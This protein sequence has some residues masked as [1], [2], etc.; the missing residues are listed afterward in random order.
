[1]GIEDELRYEYFGD[2]DVDVICDEALAHYGMPRRSGRYPW[3]SGEDPYQHEKGFLAQYEKLRNQGVKETDIAKFFGM[4]TKQLRD[5]KAIEGMKRQMAT[6]EQVMKRKE[7]GKGATEIGRELG[8]PEGTVRGYIKKAASGGVD[9]RIKSTADTLAAAVE[10]NKYIQ[11]G[12]GTNFYLGVS[13]TKL[14]NALAYLATKGYK[15][16]TIY[17]PQAGADRQYTTVKVL[18][19]D[20]V[21]KKELFD[22]RDKI[23]MVDQHSED[24]GLTYQKRE[25]I[26]NID[27]KR[28]YV[29]YGD[30]GGKDKDGTI[31]LRRNVP[32]LDLGRARYAQV[33]IGV[34]GKNGEKLY[35]KGMALYSDDIPPG[36]D[37]VYNTNKK[38]GSPDV[39]IKDENGFVTKSGVFK[40]QKDPSSRG[41]DPSNPF[42]STVKGEDELITVPSHY[43]DKDGN[44][45]KSAL[46]ICKEEGDWAEWKKNLPSQFL[47]KQDPQLARKQLDIAVGYKQNE[48]DEIKSLTNP[49]IKKELLRAFADECDSAAVHLKAAAL[50]RQST[51]VIL[52]DPNMKENEIYAPNYEHGEEVVLVRFPHGGLF[53]I[54]RLRVNKHVPSAE[55]AIGPNAKDAVVI[56]SKVAETLS[57]ADFDGDTVLVIPTK[58]NNIKGSEQ[59]RKGDKAIESLRNFD[60][61]A[62]FPPNP[63]V[64]PWKKGGSTEHRQMGEVSNLITDMTLQNAP[65]DEVIRAV[66][67]SMVVIDVAK[68]HYDYKKSYEE[69]G[70]EDLKKKYQ[71][72]LDDPTKYGG[73]ATLISK[74]K[75]VEYVNARKG[76]YKIDPETGEKVWNEK[77]PIT[78]NGEIQYNPDGTPKYNR[79]KSTKM[80]EA[81][82]AYELSSGHVIENVYADYANAMKAMGNEARKELLATPNL[83]YSPENRKTYAKQVE[84]LEKKLVDAKKNA[85]LE[86]QAQALA[87]KKVEMIEA[88]EDLTAEEKKKEKNKAISYARIVT[89][90]KKHQ[91]YIEDDEWEAIQAGAVSDSK[92]K[93]IWNNANQDRAKE[94]A[95]PKAKYELSDA[96]KSLIAKMAGR[97]T[98]QEIADQL[99]ISISTV[100][101]Y[102]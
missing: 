83:K 16:Q 99:G 10:K 72:H 19:K 1:M 44:K 32:D 41:Y 71:K 5:K 100:Q 68:H 82:D 53:E 97:Y 3:G 47:S 78:R 54:P 12:K 93:E 7:E 76:T 43:E 48:F 35:M 45:H 102:V 56:N 34:E 62:E 86:A 28:I 15:T 58:T 33:R 66:K 8:M 39:D 80:A 29:R 57:G 24:G 69:L 87:S 22:N 51:S 65:I 77:G 64:K 74:A 27:R 70:I 36:Y 9:T 38:S 96:K 40:K 50:P 63:K 4:N 79:Q 90:A 26:V 17:V 98:N 11:V 61:D 49:T 46:N 25:P 95:L 94:L 60:P 52:P 75:G 23:R 21:D 85:P 59:Y 6:F 55:K 88:E 20:N 67:H 30:E 89:G 2:L 18:T 91:I 13:E 81:K 37:A 14:G 92:L 84:S 73:A 42:G 101:K 31:E